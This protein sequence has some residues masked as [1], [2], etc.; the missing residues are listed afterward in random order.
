M[1]G[2]GG[3]LPVAR[4]PRLALPFPLA[5]ALLTP[6]SLRADSTRELTFEHDVRPILKAHCTHCHGE[7]EK[8]K[9]GVDLRLRRFMDKLTEDGD[10]ILV[11]GKPE[12]SEMVRLVR[13][14]EMPK[15]GKK[16]TAQE[17]A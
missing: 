16:L 6:P 3:R 12:D 9:G 17:L 13:E 8:P 11:A 2:Y 7:E 10:H 15:K 4:L 14:G 1:R 5:V